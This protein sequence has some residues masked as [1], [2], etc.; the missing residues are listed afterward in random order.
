MS[1]NQYSCSIFMNQQNQQTVA[2]GLIT[3]CFCMIIDGVIIIVIGCAYCSI[4]LIEYSRTKPVCFCSMID[5][6]CRMQ[7]IGIL[8]YLVFASV[9]TLSFSVFVL[10]GILKSLHIKVKVFLFCLFLIHA[11]SSEFHD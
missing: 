10:H 6:S 4:Q 5:Y 2:E 3:G 1:C 7:S 11:F 9:Y 8:L